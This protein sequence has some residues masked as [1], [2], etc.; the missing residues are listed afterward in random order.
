M[1]LTETVFWT[2]IFS[3]FAIVFVVLI[4]GGYYGVQYYKKINWKVDQV[5]IPD[6]KCGALPEIDIE[7]QKG[8]AA[9]GA[10]WQVEALAPSLPNSKVP[11]IAYVYAIDIAGEK[12]S[13]RDMAIALAKSLDFSTP[14]IHTPGSTLYT[15][16]N[17]FLKS[18]L[19]FNTNTFNFTYSRL[20]TALPTIPNQKLPSIYRAPE[21]AANYLR[22]LGL[23]T[24][25][26]A[27]GKSFAYPVVMA[28]DV[29]VVVDS[30]EK[31]QL[32]RVDFQ[33]TNQLLLYDQAIL[34]PLNIP[35]GRVNFTAFVSEQ[36]KSLSNSVKYTEIVVRRVG[37]TPTTSNMQIYM[38]DQ[39]GSAAYG[40]QQIIYNNWNVEDTPCGTYLIK[41]PSAAITMI[42]QGGGKIVYLT[43]GASD[44]L[45]P[46][47]STPLSVINLYNLELAYYETNDIQP[48]LQPIYVATGQ[49]IFQNG[50]KGEIAIYVPAI[51][52]AIPTK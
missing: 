17:S 15:W 51:D 33:K 1:T 50:A 31:A 29:P 48:Y 25:E 37:K 14:V 49:A 21:Q 38:R 36:R 10:I 52:Y 47:T 22:A 46:K 44:P 16:N 28:K 7:V 41:P 43:E 30:M 45:N 2:K 23:F 9:E 19:V 8:V 6:N 26:F 35:T 20:N 11:L 4:V 39:G 5:F 24:S 34:N 13:T 3:K 32:V 27:N 12:F 18:K 40:L 42:Q